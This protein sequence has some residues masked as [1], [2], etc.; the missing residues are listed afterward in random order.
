MAD[1]ATLF[2]YDNGDLFYTAGI[3]HSVHDRLRRRPGSHEPGPTY[4]AMG[5]HNRCGHSTGTVQAQ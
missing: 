4:V 2:V 1:V 5:S 3:A